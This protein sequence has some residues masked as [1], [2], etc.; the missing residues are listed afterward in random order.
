MVGGGILMLALL[1]G[2]VA[3]GQDGPQVRVWSPDATP[4]SVPEAWDEASEFFVLIWEDE[5]T[6]L[7]EL[8]REEVPAFL[9]IQGLI[10]LAEISQETLQYP[11]DHPLNSDPLVRAN[12]ELM[13][14]EA[15]HRL[16]STEA[17][18]LRDR[19]EI[20]PDQR[21]WRKALKSAEDATHVWES[22]CVQIG[23]AI[24]SKAESPR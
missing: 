2:V 17:E 5:E 20:E 21:P 12:T 6:R 15:S 10:A 7:R 22:N 4:T 11:S 23:E 19:L 3:C 13:S 16:W 24:K 8:E 1:V 18:L 9:D 14:C